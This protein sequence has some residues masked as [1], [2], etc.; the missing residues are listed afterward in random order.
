MK[1]R[2]DDAGANTMNGTLTPTRERDRRRI[3]KDQYE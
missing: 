1:A 3:R 2:A